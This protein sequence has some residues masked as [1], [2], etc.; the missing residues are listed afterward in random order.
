[1]D[2]PMQSES[3]AWGDL[4]AQDLEALSL[5]SDGQASAAQAERAVQAWTRQPQAR[6]FWHA[7]QVAGDGLRSPDLLTAAQ[8]DEAFLEGVRQRLAFEPVILAP[9]E[10]P[11]APALGVQPGGPKRWWVGLSAAAGLAVLALGLG[12]VAGPQAQAPQTLAAESAA[13]VA[14]VASPGLLAAPGGAA[15]WAQADPRLPAQQGQAFLASTAPRAVDLP[16]SM[17][18]PA[19]SVPPGAAP[20]IIR[21]AQLDRYLDAHQEFSAT[22]PMAE[23]AALVR[24]P[25]AQANRR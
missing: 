1:M 12:R 13:A 6:A 7:A 10:P 20:R 2:K 19:S 25:S 11:M 21:D 15:P 14:P 5:L 9:S 18:N 22:A 17:A 8:R 16:P 24:T 4:T 3:D 23:P